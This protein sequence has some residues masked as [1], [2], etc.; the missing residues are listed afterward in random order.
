MLRLTIEI[1]WGLAVF[2]LYHHHK[3]QLSFFTLCLAK[4]P[5]RMVFFYH[6]AVKCFICIGKTQKLLR[7]LKERVN[8]KSMDSPRNRRL[9]TTLEI[10]TSWVK[11]QP[12]G[13][14]TSPH[15]GPHN[16]PEEQVSKTRKRPCLWVWR[17]DVS[18]LNQKMKIPVGD[19][20]IRA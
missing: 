12:L 8:V 19:Q 16:S 13:L 4:K 18:T 9:G 2:A 14:D 6:A 17:E 15:C 20:F 5:F 11:P 1:T 7:T 3:V 10:W